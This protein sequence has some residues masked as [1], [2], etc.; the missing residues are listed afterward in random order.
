M[1]DPRK[2]CKQKTN[3]CR[4]EEQ[5]AKFPKEKRI[6]QN[7]NKGQENNQ[8]MK[9][10]YKTKSFERKEVVEMED[11]SERS[12]WNGR[13]AKKK[14]HANYCRDIHK[15]QRN[16]TNIWDHNPRMF[17]DIKGYIN[18]YTKRPHHLCG[19][20]NPE[21]STLNHIQVKLLYFKDKEKI[22]E[23]SK[24]KKKKNKKLQGQEN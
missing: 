15:Q 20:I 6:K 22:P 10:R 8:D 4:S 24:G 7:L 16:R 18:L 21:L 13:Q 11:I 3:Y 23:I 14:Q 19:K 9:R 1:L 2:K 12:S 5:I 17:Q